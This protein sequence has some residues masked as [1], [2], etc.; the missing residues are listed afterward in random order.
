MNGFP[1]S[2]AHRQGLWLSS[3]GTVAAE[4][5]L[6]RAIEQL[7]GERARVRAMLEGVSE[8]R[9]TAVRAHRSPMPR[10]RDVGALARGTGAASPDVGK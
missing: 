3:W 5:G 6:G 9:V 1:T 10:K 2:P 7:Q 8:A 4:I